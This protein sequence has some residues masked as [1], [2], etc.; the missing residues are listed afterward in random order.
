[1]KIPFL[2]NLILVFLLIPTIH[3]AQGLR[4]KIQ[5]YKENPHYLAWGDTPVFL[6]GPTG[7]HSWTPVSR[8]ATS[9]IEVQLEKMGELIK[10]V[11]SPHIMGMVRWLPYDPMNHLHDGPVK[12]VLQPWLKKEDGRYDLNEFSP[13]WEKRLRLLLDLSLDKKIIVLL[14]IWDDWSVTRGPGGAYDP[15][16]N[17]GWNGHPFN[18]NNN[19]NFDEEILSSTT[20]ACDAPFYQSIPGKGNHQTI[21]GFQKLYVDHLLEIVKDYPHVLLNV[22]N[23]SRADQTWSRFWAEYIKEKNFLI[24]DMPSTNRKDGG[25]ECHQDFNPM[26]LAQ[27]PI[28]D[29]V[30]I[31]QGVSGHEFNSPKAQAIEGGKRIRDYRKAMGN[32]IKPLVVSKDYTRDENGGDIVIWSRFMN[33]TASTRFHRPARD[34]PETVVQYQHQAMLRLGKFISKLEF[35]K[36]SPNPGSIAN[37]PDVMAANVLSNK[38]D[39]YA[40]QLL[41]SKQNSQIELNVPSGNWGITWIDPTSG[42]VLGKSKA[43]HLEKTL[44]ITV[45]YEKSHLVI[46]LKKL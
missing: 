35:W 27:D 17:F 2:L 29:F 26:T 9:T 45:P 13:V 12:E 31:S 16:E 30:D 3:F 46:L 18:P 24:G 14:E 7:Y 28:Y 4:Q 11:N 23:E 15:G 1:M 22:N 38:E 34:A 43:N 37:L 40:I 6:I 21:F 32:N 42:Q 25:G 39:T 10:A 33:G 44:I 8:P 20:S 41:D 19:I 36:M 5:I